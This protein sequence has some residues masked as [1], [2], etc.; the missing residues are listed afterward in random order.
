MP[1]DGW[2][3]RRTKREAMEVKEPRRLTSRPPWRGLSTKCEINSEMQGRIG[4]LGREMAKFATSPGMLS[5]M[6][7]VSTAPQSY[8]TGLCL[9]HLFLRRP[10]RT[11]IGQ[12]TIYASL[13][14]P[15]GATTITSAVPNRRLRISLRFGSSRPR[16]TF[17]TSITAND[18]QLWIRVTCRWCRWPSA[19]S[20]RIR[21]WP[22]CA[23]RYLQHLHLLVCLRRG[24]DSCRRPLRNSLRAQGRRVL[25]RHH[26][27]DTQLH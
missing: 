12:P 3:R 1:S 4:E 24:R 17:T 15:R 18:E 25:A 14:H 6:Q 13:R 11:R 22:S 20:T 2:S 8:T 26:G 21:C 7:V 5:T 27:N 16:R 10:P 19:L 23:P 9:L